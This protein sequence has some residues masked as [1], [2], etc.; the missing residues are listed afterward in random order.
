MN[1]DW[2]TESPIPSIILIIAKDRFRQVNEDRRQ[3]AAP[4]DTWNRA[5]GR[6]L[7]GTVDRKPRSHRKGEHVD[8]FLTNKRRELSGGRKSAVMMDRFW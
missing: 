2:R 6:V 5:T 4:A 1:L 8:R 3:C 7:A